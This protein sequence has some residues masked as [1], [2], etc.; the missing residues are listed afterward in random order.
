VKRSVWIVLNVLCAG[1]V[2]HQKI[3]GQK[4]VAWWPSESATKLEIFPGVQAHKVP[5]DDLLTL[6]R[7]NGYEGVVRYDGKNLQVSPVEAKAEANR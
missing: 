2:L 1:D 5:Y 4:F 6:A 7:R 3:D